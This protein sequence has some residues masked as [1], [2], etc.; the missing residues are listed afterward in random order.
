VPLCVPCKVL[1]KGLEGRLRK[2]QQVNNF[3]PQNLLVTSHNKERRQTTQI[4]VD[5]ADQRVGEEIV[6]SVKLNLGFDLIIGIADS[7][8]KR[9]GGFRVTHRSNDWGA[10]RGPNAVLVRSGTITRGHFEV[11]HGRIHPNRAIV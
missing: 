11:R 10:H 7:N 2:N 3:I 8:R 6:R 5:G 9:I 4:C 1:A